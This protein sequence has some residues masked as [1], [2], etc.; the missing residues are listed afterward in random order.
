MRLIITSLCLGLL[1]SAVYSSSLD[2]LPEPGLWQVTTHSLVNE[3]D[4][5]VALAQLR[6]SLIANQPAERQEMMRA[7]MAEQVGEQGDTEVACYSSKDLQI[8]TQPNLMLADLRSV[9]PP[10]CTLNN[11][12]WEGSSAYSYSGSCV[13][14]PDHDFVGELSGGLRIHSHKS[15]EHWEHNIG[16]TRADLSEYGGA[17]VEEPTEVKRT[18]KLTWLSRDCGS[19]VAFPDDDDE[20]LEWQAQ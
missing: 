1:S 12:K 17:V 10:G 20:G 6:E 8:F 5:D 14:H 18:H 7:M 4:V 9:I 2:P 19:S 15:I 3:Q 13:H 16:T 11:P